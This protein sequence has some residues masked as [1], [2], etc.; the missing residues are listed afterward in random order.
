[1]KLDRRNTDF[2]TPNSISPQFAAV[3]SETGSPVSASNAWNAP[4][5]ILPEVLRYSTIRRPF[6]SASSRPD[7]GLPLQGA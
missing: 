3:S 2:S 6:Q 4:M 7:M 1:M 5:G